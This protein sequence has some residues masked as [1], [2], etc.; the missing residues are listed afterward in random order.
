VSQPLSA[1]T[2]PGISILPSGQCAQS[3]HRYTRDGD[4]ALEQWLADLCARSGQGIRKIF[5]DS[6]LE[7]LILGGGYGRGE[8]GVLKTPD[9]DQPYNDL[10]FFVLVKGTPKLNERRY[11][12]Q[13]HDLGHQLTDAYGLEVEFKITS[14]ASIR[15]SETSMFFYDLVCGHQVTV[16][17]ADVLDGCQHHRL[18]EQIPLHET[19]RLLMNR[20]SGL[21]YAQRQ[22]QH[23]PF[24]EEDADFIGRNIAKAQ[25]ALGDA[26]LAA[27]GRFHWSCLERHE[28]L[29]N[30]ALNE[31]VTEMP[32]IVQGHRAGVEFKLHPKRSAVIQTELM[33]LHS[34]TTAVAWKVWQWIEEKRLAEQFPSPLDYARS[35]ASKCPE[36]KPL[37]NAVVRALTFGPA[38]AFSSDRFRYPRESLLRVLSLLLW[39]QESHFKETG[40]IAE[41]W[42]RTPVPTWESSI[43]AYERLWCRYN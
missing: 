36:T 7:A 30:L 10:E 34:E 33:A 27:N 19:T 18:A 26:L 16:G 12:K 28:R 25:L 42:L 22:L 43:E 31:L 41:R 13:V 20:C 3:E 21:L 29:Q 35:P 38:S 6:K 17:A 40:G 5:P 15:Q 1:T 8:G 24:T 4:D 9:G 32:A 11:G 2:E 37:K 39:N 14:L 23:T